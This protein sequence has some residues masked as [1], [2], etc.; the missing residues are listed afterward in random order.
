MCSHG[1]LHVCSKKGAFS[2]EPTHVIRENHSK[3]SSSQSGQIGALYCQQETFL[4]G[5]Q[6]SYVDLKSN[7]HGSRNAAFLTYSIISVKKFMT[8]H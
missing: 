2:I 7:D 6:E 8:T 4:N 5:V 1:L 3:S